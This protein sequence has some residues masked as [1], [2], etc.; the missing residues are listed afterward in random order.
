MW[1]EPADGD[2]LTPR[3]LSNNEVS[4]Y[5]SDEYWTSWTEVETTWPIVAQTDAGNTP[6]QVVLRVEGYEGGDF[7]LRVFGQFSRDD[8]P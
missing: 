5:G 1:I 8:Q 6:E 7:E 3:V 2:P 4:A